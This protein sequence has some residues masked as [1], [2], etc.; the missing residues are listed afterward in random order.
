M[1]PKEISRKSDLPLRTVS[2]ALRKLTAFKLLRRV[3]NLQDMRQPLY[4][5]ESDEVRRRLIKFGTDNLMKMPPTLL[6]LRK[7]I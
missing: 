5:I 1:S 7:T 4:R 2:F 6:D 3:P